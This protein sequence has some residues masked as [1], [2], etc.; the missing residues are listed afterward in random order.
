MPVKHAANP[1]DLIT[2]DEFEAVRA[3]VLDNNEGVAEE[4]AGRI[5]TEALAFVATCA[6]YR[7]ANVAPS[8]VVDEGWHALIL[9][10]HLYASLCE[11]LGGMAHHFPERPD[12]SRF[13]AGI[14]E[15]TCA[16]IEETGYSVDRELWTAPDRELV[17][18]AASCQHSGGP[19]GPITPIPR[20]KGTE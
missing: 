2:S 16:L 19:N 15:A 14:G 12:A 4:M 5:V 17:A 6:R 9:H 1:R 8:R 10:T 13:D 11:R 18:V 7:Q 3:T 20:P